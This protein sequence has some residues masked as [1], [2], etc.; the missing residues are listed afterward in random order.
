[1]GET[2]REE[3]G[4]GGTDDLF[5][6]YYEWF[7][8]VVVVVGCWCVCVVFFFFFFFFGYMCLGFNI[9]LIT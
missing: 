1:M 9:F 5:Y 4:S 7:C 2:G 8:F 6:R 3:L